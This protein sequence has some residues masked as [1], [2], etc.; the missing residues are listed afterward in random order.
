MAGNSG[1]DMAEHETGAPAPPAAH[2]A[3]PVEAPPPPPA[4]RAANPGP[5][6]EP[7]PV[8]TERQPIQHNVPPAHEITGPA[9]NPKKGWWRR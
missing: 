3:P 1:P 8:E 2:D 7:T 9:S 6:L 4:P 5:K